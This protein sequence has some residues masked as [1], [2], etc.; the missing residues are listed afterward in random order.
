MV[1][2]KLASLSQ[3][4]ILRVRIVR[5][6][7]ER[8]SFHSG[9]GTNRGCPAALWSVCHFRDVVA[10]VAVKDPSPIDNSRHP[11]VQTTPFQSFCLEH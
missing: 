10:T 2:F 7:K 9:D 3:V 6:D 4:R 1:H 11:V 5:N 8:K